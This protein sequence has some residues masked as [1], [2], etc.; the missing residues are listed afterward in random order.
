MLCC[1]SPGGNTT[2]ALGDTCTTFYT[3]YTYP[4][5]PQGNSGMALAEFALSECCCYKCSWCYDTSI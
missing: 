1:H 2:A 4:H 3:I 5:L